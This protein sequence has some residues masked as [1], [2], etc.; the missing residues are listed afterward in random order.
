[1]KTA[2]TEAAL[3]DCVEHVK[4]LNPGNK[5]GDDYFD[6]ID[7]SS[8]DQSEKV[9][10]RVTR[11]RGVEA[12]SRARQAVSPGDVLVSTVRPN[13][14]AV[15]QVT[16]DHEGAV[17]STGFCVLRPRPS[18]DSRYLFHWVQSSQFVAAMVRRATG[19]SYPAV[20]DRIVRESTFPLPPL[21]EQRRIACV[22][23]A[24]GELRRKRAA[25]D[26]RL[27]ELQRG[28]LDR[29]L[30][31]A[32]GEESAVGAITTV[33]TKGTTPTSIGLGYADEGVPFL[34]AMDLD[35]GD[36]HVGPETLH[37]TQDTHSEM[38]RSSIQAGDVLLSIAGTIGRVAMVPDDA[39][40][41]NCNQAVAIVRPGERVRSRFLR[42]ALQAGAV[43]R[44]IV[45]ATVTGTISN[46]SLAQV[47]ALSVP[48]PPL[49]AQA[50]FEVVD[51]AYRQALLRNA[52]HLS[53]L[54][55]LLAS[56]R[57]SFLTEGR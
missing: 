29:W 31:N 14:N 38:A 45:S 11:T 16:R 17:A 35:G 43:Q 36:V 22:L 9:V 28:E 41:M 18:L 26:G 34:R 7:L 32:A 19:A 42:A 39:P 54:T 30:R 25:A 6:Y 4:T 40:E 52:D 2:W 37:I 20:S 10:A 46:L 1:M 21:D 27:R 15:A 44:Q 24:V 48:V 23:D 56:L 12:P 55:A 51:T 33:V 49:A 5:F 3:G 13:L 47:R 57:H 50:E 53:G 8:V